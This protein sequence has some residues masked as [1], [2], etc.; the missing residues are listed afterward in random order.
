MK[1]NTHI[2][3]VADQVR[4]II[5]L[6]IAVTVTSTVIKRDAYISC[7]NAKPFKSGDPITRQTLNVVNRSMFSVTLIA[8]VW[9]VHASRFAII[10]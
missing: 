9:G 3:F 8:Q 2:A 1:R 5:S 7:A 6:L 4:R 10:F